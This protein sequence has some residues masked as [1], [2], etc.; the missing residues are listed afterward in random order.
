L[1]TRKTGTFYEDAACEYLQK[2]GVTI[3]E[4]NYRCRLGEIDIV[5]K[6]KNCIVF[7]EVKYRRTNQYGD[8]LMAVGYAKQ[9]KICRC[10]EVYCMYHPWVSQVRYDVIGITDTKV[11]WIQN[12]FEHHGYSW[13]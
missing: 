4:R 2:Q 12:A 6:D 7:V 9:K 8:A 13:G 1:N 11:K 10:A 3:L 5:A